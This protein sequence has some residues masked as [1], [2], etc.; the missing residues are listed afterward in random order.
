MLLL[1]SKDLLLAK[2]YCYVFIV[3]GEKY[4]LQAKLHPFFPFVTKNELFGVY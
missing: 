4:F 1:L 3:V 2:R